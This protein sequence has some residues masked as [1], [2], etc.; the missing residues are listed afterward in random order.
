MSAATPGPRRTSGHEVYEEL[1][2]G[3]ALHALEP[4]DDLRF[5]AHLA[6]C[7]LCRDRLAENDRLLGAMA[8]ALPQEEPPPSVLQGIR[9]QVRGSAAPAPQPAVDRPATPPA[10]ELAARRREVVVRRS[11]LLSAAAGVMAVVLGLG[12]WTAVLQSQR[13]AESGRADRLAA[14]VEQLER[15][16]ART[17]PLASSNGAVQLVVVAQGDSAA[18]V[19]DGLEPNPTGTAY[20]LWGQDLAGDVKPLTAFDVAE[21]G[22]AVL[23]GQQLQVPVSQLTTL[24]VTHEKRRGLPSQTVEPVV[25]VGK[26]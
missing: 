6:G 19:V 26:V 15:P 18:F 23:Q 17:V 22:L 13:D 2:V 24:M 11:W 9:A 16:D 3:H 21:G 1:A 7:D 14:A 5:S 20:V 10:D 12:I 4:E 8:A 25:L